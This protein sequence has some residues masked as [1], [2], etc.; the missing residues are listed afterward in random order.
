ME[1]RKNLSLFRRGKVPRPQS[2]KLL[3][4]PDSPA[5]ESKMW[6]FPFDSSPILRWP[7]ATSPCL[8][9]LAQIL[10]PPLMGTK[11]WREGAGGGAFQDWG[12]WSRSS[13]ARG[14]GGSLLEKG[15]CSLWEVPC[16]GAG[17]LEFTWS[18]WNMFKVWKHREGRW[19]EGSDVPP[20]P[21]PPRP[22]PQLTGVGRGA[23]R[24]RGLC[25]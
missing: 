20:C 18:C 24:W 12:W 1:N 17:L 11:P 22:A 25:P 19:L 4:N 3:Y 2:W 8:L 15:S 13:V 14:P 16:Q 9:K 7:C 23:E 6:L 5:S 10:I 21:P